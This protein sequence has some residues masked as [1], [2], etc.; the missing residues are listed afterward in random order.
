MDLQLL[1]DFSL[2]IILSSKIMLSYLIKLQDIQGV[3]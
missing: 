3:V 1:F 2:F